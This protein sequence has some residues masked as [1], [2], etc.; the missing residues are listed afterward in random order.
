MELPANFNTKLAE[1][2][3]DIDRLALIPGLDKVTSTNIHYG[4]EGS[5]DNLL[6]FFAQTPA[7]QLQTFLDMNSGKNRKFDATIKEVI[8]KEVLEALQSETLT[9]TRIKNNKYYAIMLRK[10]KEQMLK[11]NKFKVASDG[12]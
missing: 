9:L 6:D 12:T 4:K 1:N 3:K 11:L 10:I 8:G 5:K 2:R 7:K